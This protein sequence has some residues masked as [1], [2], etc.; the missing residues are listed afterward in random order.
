MSTRHKKL[1][2]YWAQAGALAPFVNGWVGEEP[3]LL[4]PLCLRLWDRD[5]VYDRSDAVTIEHAPA[6]QAGQE[7]VERCLTCR[8]CNSG[9]GGTFELKTADLNRERRDAVVEAPVTFVRAM[10]LATVRHDERQ[11]ELK[12]AYLVAFATLGYSYVLDPALDQVRQLVEPGSPELDLRTCAAMKGAENLPA[13]TISVAH[14]PIHCLLVA[15]PTGHLATSN[16]HVV[17]LP[18]PGSDTG[19]YE[20][21]EERMP[22]GGEQWAVENPVP[23]PAARDL[24]MLWD[25]DG[26]AELR[27]RAA[28]EA[29]Y[30]CDDP[31]HSEHRLTIRMTDPDERPIVVASVP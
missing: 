11:T 25:H 23:W 8:H 14:A 20:H 22:S 2:L 30:D 7:G 18:V 12:S 10:Q 26:S 17:I 31:A 21:L 29:T 3:L 24:P 15:H 5:A 27:S 19:F 13:R 9:A 16:G 4:C 1:K 28:F 6:R